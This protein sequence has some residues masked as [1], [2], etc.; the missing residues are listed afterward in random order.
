MSSAEV[1]K[2]IAALVEGCFAALDE[3]EQTADPAAIMSAA[4]P[5]LGPAPRCVFCHTPMSRNPH[6][7]A[8]TPS[9]LTQ[10][11][12]VWECVPCLVRTRFEASRRAGAAEADVNRLRDV[13]QALEEEIYLNGAH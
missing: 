2:R 3:L 9:Q 7:D 10:V 12:Y 8:G 4:T 1:R 13:I 5:A 11:G 6:P